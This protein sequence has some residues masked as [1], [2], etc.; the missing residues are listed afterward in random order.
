M[1]T[2]KVVLISKGSERS[3]QSIEGPNHKEVTLTSGR[4]GGGLVRLIWE[5]KQKKGS[6]INRK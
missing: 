4:E 5:G 3:W 2:G 1:V 6:H